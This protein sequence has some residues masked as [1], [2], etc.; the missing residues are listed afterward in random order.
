MKVMKEVAPKAN[1]PEQLFLSP[2]QVARLADTVKLNGLGV[3][4]IATFTG[5]E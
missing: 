1:K 3:G 5:V 2:E 4:P